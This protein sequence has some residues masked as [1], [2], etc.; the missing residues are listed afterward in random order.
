LRVAILSD[1]HGNNVA[2][3]AV[4]SDLKKIQPDMLVCLGDV[5]VIGP[6]P[7]KVIEQL[8]SLEC[9]FVMGNTDSWVLA[10]KPW[11]TENEVQQAFLEI[12]LWCAQQLSNEDLEF[13]SKFQSIQEIIIE[14]GEIMLCC[15]GSPRSYNDVIGST[16]SEEELDNFLSGV[17]AKIL[18]SGHTHEPMYRVYQD[19]VLINPGSVGLPRIIKGEQVRHPLW[20]EYAV[21][22]CGNDDFGLELRRTSVKKEALEQAVADSGMPH[23]KLWLRDW[24]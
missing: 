22:E 11:E 1:I 14:N 5:A 20:A 21:V 2:L 12:E 4:L 8:R 10:P 18:V 17:Q 7:Q 9:S 23:A 6:H 15:H 19:K 13:I 24:S 3:E 16:T